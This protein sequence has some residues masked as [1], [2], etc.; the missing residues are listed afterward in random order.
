MSVLDENQLCFSTKSS[1]I[2]WNYKIE[3][4]IMHSQLNVL[5]DNSWNTSLK[6]K[7]DDTTET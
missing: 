6:S 2:S 5:V 3:A 7:F 4:I 1:F